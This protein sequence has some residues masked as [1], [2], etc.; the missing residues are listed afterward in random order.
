[1]PTLIYVHDPMCSWCWGFSPCLDRLL[2]ALPDDMRL[3]RL[4]GGLAPDSGE[5]MPEATREY[6]QGQWHQIQRAIPGTE[7]NYDFW[8]ACAPR[9]ATYPA[10]RAV[11]AARRQGEEFDPLMTVAIQRAYYLRAMN[12]SDVGTLSILAGELGLDVAGFDRDLV[13]P[14]VDETLRAEIREARELGVDGFP[15]LVFVTGKD[16]R[17]IPVDYTDHRPMLASVRAI[18]NRS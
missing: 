2:S 15:G 5:P 1:M 8:T 9:R 7:F 11:I 16:R 13:S 4:L 3:R 12:P 10:C 6:V 17:W 14:E 18:V